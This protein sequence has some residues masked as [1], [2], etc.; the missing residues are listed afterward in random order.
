MS[1]RPS[2][3]IASDCMMLLLSVLA[4]YWANSVLFSQAI[5]PMAMNLM[6][7][8]FVLLCGVFA[9]RMAGHIGLPHL[10]GYLILGVCVGPQSPMF[11]GDDSIYSMRLISEYQ[12]KHH[13]IFVQQLAIGLIALMAG[14]EIRMAWL[15]T[16]I[17]GIINIVALQSIVVPTCII[18]LII[19]LWDQMP[20]AEAA[21]AAQVSPWIVAAL[22]G[23]IALAN[24]PM[25]VV[26][27]IK[28]RKATGPLSET[29]MGVSVFKD[30][31]VIMAF[32]LVISLATIF[33]DGGVGDSTDIA[34][35]GGHTLL[36]I[37]YSV[38]VGFAI[39]MLL[40]V[41]TQRTAFRLTWLLI[42]LAT[43]VAAIEPLG[44]KPLFCL[45]AA[46]FACENFGDRSERG[47]HR[48]E[49][50]LGRVAAPVFI[51]FFVAAGLKLHLDALYLSWQIIIA[52]VVTRAV[53]LYMS[54]HFAA[55]MS[56]LEES[57][58]R[59]TWTAMIP[60]AG[61]SI[62]LA[63]IIAH[64]FPTWGGSLET[65]II[66]G[67]AFHELVG[68]ILFSAALKKSGEAQD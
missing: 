26:S 5:P 60:Q 41:F 55:K 22:V 54:V 38:L 46:G 58:C 50:A 32:T 4:L 63:T 13:L 47:S 45:L 11:F 61:V 34:E 14:V 28:E 12:L 23:I 37:F 21:T 39:G 53:A 15:R 7:P 33:A 43:V 42:G 31:V 67:I 18:A 51:L 48:L 8:G 20:M 59:H 16:R 36:K 6:V 62:S 19:L 66:A 2:M 49:S 10:T 17:R 64:K 27:V 1:K 25:V 57:V 56:K 68:P 24:S 35:A 44:I 52:L 9:G 3:K 30:V 29:A 40:Q 65:M